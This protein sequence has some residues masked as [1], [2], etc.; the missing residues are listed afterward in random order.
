MRELRK[1]NAVAESHW[2]V[3]KNE[4]GTR[5]WPNHDSARMALFEYIEVFYTAG[6]YAN[7]RRGAT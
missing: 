6:G 2:A 5:Q 3:I 1:D 7:T 4:L